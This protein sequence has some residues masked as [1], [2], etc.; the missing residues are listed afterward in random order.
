MIGY[1]EPMPYRGISRFDE[2]LTLYWGTSFRTRSSGTWRSAC[3]V[4]LGDAVGA[5]LASVDRAEEERGREVIVI[6]ASSVHADSTDSKS[7]MLP[8]CLAPWKEYTGWF[9]RARRYRVSH[10][11]RAGGLSV[12]QQT[13]SHYKVDEVEGCTRNAFKG[14]GCRGTC[15]SCRL[16]QG[17]WSCSAGAARMEYEV[18]SAEPTRPPATTGL[19]FFRLFHGG[20]PRKAD[21]PIPCSAADGF[22]PGS[23]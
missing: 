11:E 6:R 17:R 16:R 9:G 23:R 10:V 8:P 13:L 3:E 18:W 22:G 1:G 21:E 12:Q 15:F 19:C 5:L 14:E 4:I 7:T 20:P 2:L